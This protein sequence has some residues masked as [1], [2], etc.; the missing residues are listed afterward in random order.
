MGAD[1]TRQ[2]R[3]GGACLISFCLKIK[4]KNYKAGGQKKM[5]KSPIHDRVMKWV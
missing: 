5:N 2:Q 4:R 1:K 3:D